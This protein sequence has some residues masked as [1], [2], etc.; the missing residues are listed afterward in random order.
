MSL[1][2]AS[3]VCWDTKFFYFNPRPSQLNSNIK[4]LTGVPNFPAYISG[5]S[6]FSGAAAAILSHINP[7]KASAYNAMAS[8]ASNSRMYG[9]IHFRSDCEVGL[10][11]GKNVGN[12]AV[13]RARTDGAE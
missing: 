2:D 4:T 5:H 7:E 8:E 12:Y 11:V 9:G 10:A 13:Q 3:I 6:T 1:M